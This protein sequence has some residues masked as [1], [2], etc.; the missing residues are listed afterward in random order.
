MWFF[1]FVHCCHSIFICWFFTTF[2][3]QLIYYFSGDDKGALI[4][5]VRSLGL[6]VNIV[7]IGENF[8]TFILNRLKQNLPV[9]FF[10]VSPSLLTSTENV[11]RIN[12]PQ[13]QTKSFFYPNSC[14]FDGNQYKKFI[15]TKIQYSAPE[16]YYLISKMNFNDETYV[17]LL[18]RYKFFQSTQKA[19]CNWLRYQQNEWNKWI[20]PNLSSKVKVSLLSFFPLSGSRWR[21]PGLLQ[22]KICWVWRFIQWPSAIDLHNLLVK[23]FFHW[24][25]NTCI[26]SPTWFSICM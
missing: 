18:K 25:I 3:L 1:L 8:H 7:W 5:Q 4:S 12:F 13:C 10:D 14:D 19:A 22:G 6:P 17:Q 11:T 20:P 23:S 16:V 24:W 2:L 15:W 26:L 9:M 21:Q